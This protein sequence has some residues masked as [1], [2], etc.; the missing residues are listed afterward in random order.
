MLK[1]VVIARSPPTSVPLR[2]LNGPTPGSTTIFWR[3][4]LAVSAVPTTT[5]DP[6]SVTSIA[7]RLGASEAAPVV[8]KAV[9]VTRS[10][11]VLR[12]SATSLNACPVVTADSNRGVNVL[13]RSVTGFAAFP[14]RSSAV[15]DTLTSYSLPSF[16]PPDG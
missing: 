14:A 10:F 15:E 2:V 16:R 3:L 8:A 13:M 12:T 5:G 9:V 1:V 11:T 7:S 4:G 6:T